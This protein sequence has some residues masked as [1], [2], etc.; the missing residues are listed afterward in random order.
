[1]HLPVLTQILAL[2]ATLNAPAAAQTIKIRGIPFE[3]VGVPAG[4]FQMGSDRAG[5]RPLHRVEVP[6]FNLGK[7]E[8]TIRQ[9]RAFAE[10]TGYRTDAERENWGWTCCASRPE[11]PT[12]R[13]RGYWQRKQ[14]AT[15]RNPGFTQ[16]DDDPVVEISWHDAVEF[17]KWLSSETGQSYRLPSEAEWEYAAR[18]G[19]EGEAPAELEKF[20]WFIDN[21]DLKTHPVAARQPNAWGLYDMLG[22]AWE[23]VADVWAQDYTGAP[24]DGRPRLEGGSAFAAVAAGDGRPLRG[25]GWGL[26]RAESRF[27]SRPAFGLHDRCNNSGFRVARSR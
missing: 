25:G 14:G 27:A 21:S 6:A 3:F 1:M 22:N 26:E 8:V 20:A 17:C 2:A 13:S 4:T 23:W 10:A 24:S 7:T 12:W 15:W 5:E 9:F 16:S 11:S 19:N 18:A